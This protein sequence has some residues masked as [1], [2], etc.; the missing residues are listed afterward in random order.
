MDTIEQLNNDIQSQPQL[1]PYGHPY[2]NNG[3]INLKRIAQEHDIIGTDLV[4]EDMPEDLKILWELK[5]DNEHYEIIQ[6]DNIAHQKIMS[7]PF[8]F[9]NKVYVATLTQLQS[10]FAFEFSCLRFMCAALN[11]FLDPT[12]EPPYPGEDDDDF[13]SRQTKFQAQKD[14][15]NEKIKRLNVQ[16]RE[17]QVE[18]IRLNSEIGALQQAIGKT[19]PEEVA[20]RGIKLA[21][22]KQ[23]LAALEKDR[24]DLKSQVESVAEQYR[25]TESENANYEKEKEEYETRLR[26]A[27]AK[28]IA[29]I[30][31]LERSRELGS[32]EI[33]ALEQLLREGKELIQSKTKL[34]QELNEEI[35][36][37]PDRI[38]SKNETLSKLLE[39]I[40]KLQLE[41]SRLDRTIAKRFKQEQKKTRDL[42]RK[43]SALRIKS[44]YWTTLL[45]QKTTQI[46]E[47]T[48]NIAEKVRKSTGIDADV[49]RLDEEFK[50]LEQTMNTK[51]SEKEALEK[52]IGALTTELQEC[53]TT[54]KAAED[55]FRALL[56]ANPSE[57]PEQYLERLTRI[58][59]S[60]REQVETLK[61]TAPGVAMAFSTRIAELADILARFHEIRDS[62]EEA[63]A[64]KVLENTLEV[65]S[66]EA[67][68]VG[69][70]V[71]NS[72]PL[73]WWKKM[74]GD[75]L[76]TVGKDLER[77]AWI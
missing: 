27:K 44:S 31:A 37:L 49:A 66:I 69:G 20:A 24:D 50:T 22:M 17:K 55:E 12:M 53:E 25:S 33:S 9:E 23:E 6:V 28:L 16:F 57:I 3:K 73:G 46:L 76:S 45:T 18:I 5:L 61:R 63:G 54:T 15:M 51:L 58:Q 38:E 62:A 75:S 72:F 64:G 14:E 71:D 30:A 74:F 47:L 7:P 59:G 10:S 40:T 8:R 60:L 52:E 42:Q 11:F 68:G 19:L 67:I 70:T 26:D 2:I 65:A 43:L 39:T 41:E 36:R 1:I 34:I 48:T 35:A 56:Q 13:D 32:V 21:E 29:S 4:M 77:S